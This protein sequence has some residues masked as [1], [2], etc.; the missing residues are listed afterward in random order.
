MLV[1]SVTAVE[2]IIVFIINLLTDT[3][4]CLITLAVGGSL[5]VAISVAEDVGNLLN[6]T[7]QSIGDELG[8][9][10]GDLQKGINGLMSDF[11]KIGSLFTGKAPTPPKVDF[12]GEITKLNSIQLPAGYDQGLEK[13]NGSIPTFA[14]VNNFTNMALRLPFEEV[15]KLLNESLP[16]YT[17]NS[18]MF[19]VPAKEKLTFCSDNNGISDFFDDLVN[20]EHMVKKIFLATLITLAILAMVPMAYRELRR[21]RFMQERARLIKSD[22]HD[23]LDAVYLASRPY[24]SSFGLMIANKFKSSRR[25][26]LVRWSVAYATT[27]PALFVLSLAVAG[28]LGCLCQYILLKL[29]EKEVPAL[30][31]QVGDFADKVVMQLNNASE[32]WATGTNDM[33]NTRNVKINDDVFGWVNTTTGAVNHT[34]NV[35]V[36]GMMK[37]LN[38]TF[39]GTVLYEPI[40]G[41]LNCLVLLKI[42]G[43]QKGLTWVSDHAKVDFPLVDP[44]TFSLGAVEKVSGSQASILAA[45]PGEGAADDI[46]DAVLHVTNAL[47][48]AVRQESI[49]STCVLIIWF[50]IAFIGIIRA[51]VL[52]PRGGDDGTFRNSPDSDPIAEGRD[53][54]ELDSFFRVPTYEQATST[55]ALGDHSANKLNGQSYTLQ[56]NPLPTFQ[57]NLPPSP[58]IH[59]EGGFSSAKAEKLGAVNNQSVD[60]AV[61]RQT[62]VRSSSYGDYAVTS[63]TTPRPHLSP[64]SNFPRPIRDPF[65]D[66]SR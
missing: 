63:P 44:N 51:C 5:H 21:W 61:R 31:N 24:T 32:Q 8:D 33:I 13:L 40:V 55:T 28:L 9:A 27:V 17:L 59:D 12:S 35:F 39:G 45:G 1:M 11:S 34:L 2:E 16:R 48:K 47:Y 4:M 6:S 29:I 46:A 58:I 49:I 64:N 22:A 20:I 18:S 7:V 41:V 66:P 37:E 54:H 14:E 26:A 52:L 38:D 25:K 10:A 53:K 19:P 36:D 3:Y 42:Q 50:I 43:V 57:V 60:A 15:K 56:P 65:L 23:P 30:T 62:H